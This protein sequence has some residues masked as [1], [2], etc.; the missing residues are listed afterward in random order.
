MVLRAVWA[1]L[2]WVWNGSELVLYQQFLYSNVSYNTLTYLSTSWG[3]VE[4]SGNL[5]I[6]E[7]SDQNVDPAVGEDGGA[8]SAHAEASGI[9]VD[10]DPSALLKD[11]D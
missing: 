7:W 6:W 5:G 2:E 9:R 1:F 10:V 4:N 3:E 8:G 11:S